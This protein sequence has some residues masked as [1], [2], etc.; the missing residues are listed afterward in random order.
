MEKAPAVEPHQDPDQ[1]KTGLTDKSRRRFF[2]LLGGGI[3]VTFV[4]QD[5]FALFSDSG[6]AGSLRKAFADE[7]GA[8]LHIGENNI[9]TVYTGKVEVGQNIRTSLAQVVAEELHVPMTS[10]TMV[11]GDTALTPYDAGTFGSRSTP[12]MGPQ[13]RRAAATA[14]EMVLDLAAKEWGTD[15]SNLSI[16]DGK[17]THLKTKKTIRFGQITKGKQ[18]LKVISDDTLLTPVDAWKV[19]GK[20]VKKVNGEEMLTGKHKYVS[21]M[22]LPGMLYGKILRAPSFKATVKSADLSAA[23]ALAGVVVVQEDNF[24]G[25][26]APDR[27]TAEKAI[28]ALK[29][30]WSES[31]QPSR[32]EL[33]TYLKENASDGEGRG[34]TQ[35][36]SI[37]NGMN[38]A[39]KKLKENYTIDYIAHAP[40][41]PRAALAQWEDGQLTVWTGTQRPFGVRDDLAREFN[42]SKEKVRVIMPDTGSA[43]GGKHSGEAALEAARLAKAAQ[44]PV[45]LTWTREEEFT[46]AYFRP[47]GVIEVNS[48]IKDDG[49]LTS[50]EFHN[51]N[52]GPSGIRTPY[53]VPH[54][55]IQYHPVESPL[56]QGSY[57]G[58]ASTANFFVIESQMNDLASLAKMDPLEFRLKNLEEPRLRAVFEA[59]AQSFGWGKTKPAQGHGYGIGGGTEKGGFTATCAEVVV[60]PDSG[61]VKVIRT[62]TAFECGAIINPIHLDNQILGAIVQGLGGA[63]FEAID[64]ED[65][66]ILNPHFAQYRVPRF[67]DM[68]GI[69]IIQINRKDLPSAGAG[70]APIVGIAPAIRNAIAQA[71]GVRLKS[72]PLVPKGMKGMLGSR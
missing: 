3:A 65:G 33:F 55:H 13:L 28:K 46:W 45:K 44:K 63:L 59:A 15:R 31:K 41:E 40:M 54:Q 29:V 27:Q 43:Y 70:E 68:P 11:M 18:L 69:E 16:S 48:G 57:R 10:I 22:K 17:V 1:E 30:Q 61:Q 64:F 56:K 24:I 23:K 37:E 26:V 32:S 4:L 53:V 8:W 21:D 38:S 5:A 50:W 58:L 52:S 9:V 19:A 12:A 20:S 62:T 7:V 60:D 34:S 36:G 25:I 14:R 66:K 67:K 6:N 39:T 42:L 49:T 35:K 2:K 51:Y 71:T 47:A 72:L